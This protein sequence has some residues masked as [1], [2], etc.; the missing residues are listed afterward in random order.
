MSA[1]AT[2]CALGV[3]GICYVKWENAKRERGERDHR[4]QGI[5]EAEEKVLGYRHPKFR[6]ME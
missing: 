4:L 1:E 3:I 2:V 6:Y 5:S